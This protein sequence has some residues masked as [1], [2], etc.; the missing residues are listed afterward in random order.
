[1]VQRPSKCRAAPSLVAVALFVVLTY[2]LGGDHSQRLVVMDGESQR[3]VLKC[4]PV[5]APLVSRVDFP[6]VVLRLHEYLNYNG[7]VSPPGARRVIR[8][9]EVGARECL[10]TVDFIT[11]FHARNPGVTCEAH[12]V[13]SWGFRNDSSTD[14]NDEAEGLRH[15]NIC[16]KEVGGRPGVTLHR[17]LATTAAAT[18]P[19]E[20]FDFVYIDAL[21]TY[22]GSKSD[23]NA[24]YP[25]LKPYGFLGGDD[26]NDEKLARWNFFP[27]E[28]GT[29]MLF[30]WGV[31]RAV[32]ELAF[33]HNLHIGFTLAEYKYLNRSLRYAGSSNFYTLKPPS[34][35][36]AVGIDPGCKMLIG[37]SPTEVVTDPD[38]D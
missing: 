30:H 8:W 32:Q 17:T 13:D 11:L 38:T 7:V 26:V 21:H 15:Y 34:S 3:H 29:A 5:V 37:P 9:A 18:F 23:F 31:V 35:R 16:K 25:K 2:F 33:K 22:E 12:I 10:L 4:E 36:A 14:N 24:W 1:M 27:H 19:D 20:F 28:A 6:G